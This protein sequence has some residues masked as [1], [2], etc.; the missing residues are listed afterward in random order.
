M[1][2]YTETS[3]SYFLETG[4]KFPRPL[5]WAMGAVKLAASLVNGE[6]GLLNEGVAEAI[7]R[8]SREVMEGR[9]DDEVV[10]DIFGTGSGTG[11]N[12][13]VNEI[14]AR[15]ASEIA[16]REVHPN[17]HVNLG[18][19]S[20]DVVPSAIRMAAYREIGE[21]LLPAL[22]ELRERLESLESRYKGVMRPGR[23]HL[24]DA[25]PTTFGQFFGS[26][27]EELRRMEHL[28]R[29]ASDLLLDV[30]LGG[31]AVGTGLNT[32]P[33]FPSR[34]VARL[35]EI[36]GLPLREERVRSR[37]M[38]LVSDLVAVS[39]VLRTLAVDLHRLSQDIRLMF[40]GPA[41]G[42]NEIRLRIGLAGSS[43]MPGKVN[44]VTQEAVQMASSHVIGLDASLTSAGLL[45]ELELS[46]GIPLAGWTLIREVNLLSEAMSKLARSLEE[47]EVNER[48]CEELAMSSRALIT[49]LAPLIGYERA[50]RLA[51]ELEKGR[52]V[53][54]VL[55]E[56]GVDRER[57]RRILSKER[58]V[59]PGFPALDR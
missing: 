11:L 7:G 19:S 18:Q 51:E 5:I 43:I 57:V 3:K 37:S 54:D 56:M 29:D 4:T 30:P 25:L 1:S 9:W 22:E 6:L 44:P 31:T 14:I 20:N 2:G 59:S 47:V 26:F 39:G 13:N 32:H 42:F 52:R 27:S 49:I 12:M 8:A 50:G 21:R 53:E 55:E 10:V 34:V 33:E 41:T 23:T 46:M 45:G 17:D 35:R 38:R 16:G 36:T 40:S 28:V 48:R 24:R 58:L 15:R